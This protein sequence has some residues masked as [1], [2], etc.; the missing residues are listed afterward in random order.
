MTRTMPDAVAD[1]TREELRQFFQTRPDV[2]ADLFAQYTNLAASTVRNF[3]A[4]H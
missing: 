3:L 4:G 1:K 2:T